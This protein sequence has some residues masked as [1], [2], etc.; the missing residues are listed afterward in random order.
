MRRWRHLE[1]TA[2]A[3]EG[4]RPRGGRSLRTAR[5]RAAEG[6]VVLPIRVVRHARGGAAR[7]RRTRHRADTRHRGGMLWSRQ[8]SW[9]R[10]AWHDLAG[11]PS[12][13]DATSPARGERRP[14]RRP[15]HEHVCAWPRRGMC[16]RYLRVGRGAS[17]R[18]SVCRSAR[19]AV[20]DDAVRESNVWGVAGTGAHH[21]AKS[22]GFR[23][24][25]RRAG[26]RTR[27]DHRTRHWG[28][29]AGTLH[30]GRTC[31][32]WSPGGRTHQAPP[33]TG[34]TT[35]RS[36]TTHPN[37]DSVLSFNRTATCLPAALRSAAPPRSLSR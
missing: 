37:P 21:P 29:G 31:A 32:P 36:Y 11:E 35:Y 19:D 16:L 9:T 8:S 25:T 20:A 26:D 28:V 22:F 34:L 17:R 33:M 1:S 18:I 30:V 5:A 7:G 6:L 27:N 13:C 15:L 3:S 12:R 23:Y 4:R 24:V 10:I 2:E 14:R